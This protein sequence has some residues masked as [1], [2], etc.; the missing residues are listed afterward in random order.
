[1]VGLGGEVSEAVSGFHDP[2][3][4]HSLVM[5][6]SWLWCC[7]ARESLMAQERNFRA[8]KMWYSGVSVG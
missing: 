7:V 2:K 4:S 6:S 8:W 3:R 1:M 5:A